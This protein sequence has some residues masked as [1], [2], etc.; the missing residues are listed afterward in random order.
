MAPKISAIH[1][2]NV[3]SSGQLSQRE[4]TLRVLCEDG[5]Y[6]WMG[7]QQGEAILHVAVQRKG[8]T[9]ASHKVPESIVALLLADDLAVWEPG[10]AGI[11]RRLVASAAGRAHVA[12]IAAGATHPFLAQH[13]P[14][15]QRSLDAAEGAGKTTFDEGESPLAWLARRKGRDGRAL[16]DAMS[17]AAGERLRGDM[18]LAQMLPRLTANWSGTG[19]GQ[20]GGGG[21]TYSDIVLAARQKVE[22]AL[23]AAGP[24]LSGILVDVCG[25]LKGLELVE[26][27]RQ[28]PQRSAKIV[29]VIAL[30]RLA[31][32]Y[33]MAGEARG[34]SQSRGLEHWGAE[35]FRP[36]LNGQFREPSGSQAP[37]RSTPA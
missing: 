36:A 31:R 18:T 1:A 35:D 12:R 27:E 33:G 9:I 21:D 29:L 34:P 15:T 25:F 28:W 5:A 24:E 10:G 4:R 13:R 16:I 14:L 19:G 23:A 7:T 30:T 32:H 26:T 3:Q 17:L 22:R 6:G 8:V 37:S 2:G 20:K 11:R